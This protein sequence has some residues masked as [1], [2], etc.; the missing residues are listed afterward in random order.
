MSDVSFGPY[1]VFIRKHPAK[2]DKG[3]IG[4]FEELVI[5]PQCKIAKTGKA[6]ETSQSSNQ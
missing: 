3:Q 6:L 5:L 4:A 1:P 2:A